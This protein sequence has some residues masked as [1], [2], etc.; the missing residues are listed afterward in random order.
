MTKQEIVKWIF[1]HDT[2]MDISCFGDSDGI[3]PN[4]PCPLLTA[5]GDCSCSLFSAKEAAKS[6]LEKNGMTDEELTNGR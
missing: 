4:V 5:Y 3:N 1:E 6:W 2:C